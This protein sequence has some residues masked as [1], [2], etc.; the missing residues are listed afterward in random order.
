MTLDTGHQMLSLDSHANFHRGPADEIHTRPH[1]HQLADQIGSRK[2]TR[3]TETVTQG[4]RACRIA[5]TAAAV[6]IIARITPPKTLFRLL[7]CCGIMSWEVS[8]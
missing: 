6:S 7:E 8:C 1:Y 5:Q 3:S 4:M 2:S